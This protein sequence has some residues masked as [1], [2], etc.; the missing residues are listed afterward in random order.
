MF[1]LPALVVEF[2]LVVAAVAAAFALAYKLTE[3]GDAHSYLGWWKELFLYLVSFPAD[4]QLG[5]DT[6]AGRSVV[7]IAAA[8]A[9]LVLPALFVGAVVLK[10]FISPDLFT[11]RNRV[12]LMPNGHDDVR[13]VP[14]GHHLAVRGYSSTP[15]RML[16]VT[17]SAILRFE[18]VAADGTT[19]LLH[20]QLKVANPHY[21]VAYPHVAYT[22]AVPID[23]GDW[24]DG[25]PEGELESLQG[26]PLAA[27]TVMIVLVAG[28]VPEL[29]SD[30][31]EAHDFHLTSVISH[32]PYAG[33]EVDYSIPARD[34]AGWDVFDER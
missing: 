1:T 4:P 5:A 17:F 8:I 27:G 7:Q 19:N 25:V 20:R 28:R 23:E 13:L 15:F 31:T 10:L 22:L 32:Q 26:L 33:L 6:G 11:M 30:F 9:G 34:W 12:P 18:K 29:S 21:A 3:G 2:L 16:N 14:G 24:K